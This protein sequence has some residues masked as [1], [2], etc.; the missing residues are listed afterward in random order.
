MSVDGDRDLLVQITNASVEYPVGGKTLRAVDSVSLVI[1]KGATFGLIGE[2]GSGKST[3]ARFVMGL[4]SGSGQVVVGGPVDERQR[5]V[6]RR[7]AARPVQMIVQDPHSALDPRLSIAASVAEPLRALGVAKS[8]RRERSVAM[9]ERVGLSSQL[10]GRYPHQLSGGQKQRVNIARALISDPQV[11]I[12]DESV[13]ALDVALQAEILNLL[14]DL[15]R[16]FGL[17]MLFISHDLS[18]IAHIADRIGVMY[19]GQIVE[20]N[21]ATELLVSPRHP[22]TEALIAARPEP[23]PS[24][25]RVKSRIVLEGEIPSPMSPP[26]GCRFRTRCRYAQP[27]CAEEQPLLRI[28]RHSSLV[29]CH[30]ADELELQGAETERSSLV[31]PD[32]IPALY[33]PTI[34]GTK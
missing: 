12:C 23:V 24:T 25:A 2:S 30:Y 32:T 5:P 17:T 18:V 10:A 1:E 6:G 29:A 34:G 21:E 9:L 19:L 8:Q 13:S 26:S 11:L 7:R 20:T 3:L 16:D 33:E 22:Y 31:R 4:V 15:Q 27:R 28:S 14:T